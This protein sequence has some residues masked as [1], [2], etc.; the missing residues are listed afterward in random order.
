MFQALCQ[1]LEFLRPAIS[2]GSVIIWSAVLISEIFPT[3]FE[4]HEE[5][6]WIKK[7]VFLGFDLLS[8][9]YRL[10]IKYL[11]LAFLINFA[12]CLVPGSSVLSPY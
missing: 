11:P 10:S 9:S 1:M 2:R 3:L 7:H 5:S 4:C 8:S 12:I 6:S